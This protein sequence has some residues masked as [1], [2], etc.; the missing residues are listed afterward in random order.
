MDNRGINLKLYPSQEIRINGDLLKD[1]ENDDILFVD[2]ESRYLL[3]EFPTLSIPEYTEV[4]F[5]QLRQKGITPVIV[6]PEQKQAIIDDPNIL[7]SFIERGALAQV[8]AASYLGVFGKD[9]AR[10]SCRLIEANLVHIIRYRGLRIIREEEAFIIKSICPTGKAI[11]IRKGSLFQ[12]KCKTSAMVMQCIRNAVEVST[13][14]KCSRFDKSEVQLVQLQVA[15]CFQKTS[16]RKLDNS[17]SNL[18]KVSCD[19]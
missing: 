12:G 14:G 10:V 8:T 11:W 9:V 1:I 6:H 3:I 13:K 5:F 16:M 7:L 15:C 2:E 17:F 18:P 19:I 4:L